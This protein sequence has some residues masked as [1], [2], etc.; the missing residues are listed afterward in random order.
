MERK[1]IIILGIILAAV[2]VLSAFFIYSRQEAKNAVKGIFHQ[3]DYRIE[4]IS[5]VF[6]DNHFGYRAKIDFSNKLLG[7][8]GKMIKIKSGLV[9][10]QGGNVLSSI[11]E[12][13]VRKILK[14]QGFIE[15]VKFGNFR[16]ISINNKCQMDNVYRVL[17]K[18]NQKQGRFTHKEIYLDKFGNILYS[19]LAFLGTSPFRKKVKIWGY[20]PEKFGQD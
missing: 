1:K 2:L 13:E 3:Q 4:S 5:P 16:I 18:L 6:F 19:R 17:V 15:K 12:S 7:V 11:P 10:T 20:G 9:Y 8:C 14:N